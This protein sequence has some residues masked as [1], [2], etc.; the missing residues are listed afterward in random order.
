M[1]LDANSLYIKKQGGSYVN[2]GTYLTQVEYGWNKLWGKDTGRSL[3][4][5]TTGTFLGI[6][7]KLKLNFRRLTRTELE[8]ISP[9]LNSP[10]QITKF[11]YPDS[12]NFIEIETYTGDWT[13]LNKH[14][15]EKVAKA[16]ESF[17]ISV[18]ATTP[19]R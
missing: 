8:T 15:F 13:T 10:W 9:I 2:L 3:S 18:I 12:R 7:P 4:G 19:R 11:Y 14:S 5:K 17:E 1:F 16:N 6:V